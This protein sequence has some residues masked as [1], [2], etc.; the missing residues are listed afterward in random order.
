[1]ARA[2]ISKKIQLFIKFAYKTTNISF[3]ILAKL[4]LYLFGALKQV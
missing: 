4:L 1:M 2:T 3:K